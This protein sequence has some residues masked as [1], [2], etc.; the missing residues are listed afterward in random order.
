VTSLETRLAPRLSGCR[1]LVIGGLNVDDHLHVDALPADDGSARVVD[2]GRDFGGHAGNA[3][4][5]LARLGAAV[6]V[7]GAVGC[8]PDGDALIADL[9]QQ[10]VDT[11][12][13]RRR[14]EAPTGRVIIPHFPGLRYMLMD[15]GANDGWSSTPD[16]MRAAVDGFDAI[17]L[18]DPPPAV[19]D[20]LF[21]PPDTRPR[22]YW[23]PGGLLAGSVWAQSRLRHADVLI[24]NRVEAQDAFGTARPA[25]STQRFIETLGRDGARLWLDG[26]SVHVPGYPA[27][28]EDETGAGDAFTA[29]FAA[30]DTIG[31]E[32]ALA[33]RLAN[34]AGA[35]AV[36]GRGARGG[37]PTLATLVRRW[38][39]QM[40]ATARQVP[41]IA[42]AARRRTAS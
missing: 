3:A 37:L 33:L 19:A 38:D 26:R 42:A 2:R 41:S 4:C 15:R 13:V 20:A 28:V 17:V 11:S 14:P 27:N 16:E 12:R 10:G 25:G 22:L 24:M 34:A 5:A 8:D 39:V 1:L 40:P 29:A 6:A 9:A 23:N 32:P 36:E 30:F 31:V 35:C 21:T 7:C 18:F